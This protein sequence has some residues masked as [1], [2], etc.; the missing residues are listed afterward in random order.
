MATDNYALNLQVT[1]NLVKA[2]TIFKELLSLYEMK[3]GKHGEE[4]LPILSDITALE[5]KQVNGVSEEEAKANA[6][7]R[8]KLY[9]RHNSDE[10][11]EQF[12]DKDLP[13]TQHAINAQKKASKYF[14][15]PFHIYETEHW[16]IIYSTSNKKYI[17]NKVAKVMET[18]YRNNISFLVALGL[19]NKPIEEKMTA[20]ILASKDDYS[21]YYRSI[22]GDKYGSN[23]SSSTYIFKEKAIFMFERGVNKKGKNLKVNAKTIVHSVSAQVMH[24][25]GLRSLDVKYSRWFTAGLSASFEYNNIKKPFGPHTNNYAF[26]R[27]LPI[28]KR[29]NDGSLIT[30]KQLVTFDGSDEEFSNESNQSDIYALGSILIRFLYTYY[31][32]EFKEYLTIIAKSRTT[33]YERAKSGRNLRLKQFTKAFG[34]PEAMQ[35]D[36]S[37][38]IEKVIE[39]TDVAYIEAKKR[40]QE[41]ADK[42][43]AK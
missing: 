28:K 20:V 27:V 5:Q 15:E 29:F 43:K 4:L 14:K 16:S 26:R 37:I 35:A 22:T 39:E 1:E 24:K 21:R 18:T 34:D 9:L 3:Y 6:I 31:P 10:F 25:T 23:N 13:T 36:F 12:E 41:R 33:K 19:R 30:L 7:R 2:H 42:K 38:F 32:A 11:V 17:K 40:K 8:Y